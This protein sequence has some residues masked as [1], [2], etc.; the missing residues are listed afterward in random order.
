[1]PKRTP[2]CGCAAGIPSPTRASAT[3]DAIRARLLQFDDVI[4]VRAF[5]NDSQATDLNGVPPQHVWII[6]QGGNDEAIGE[7]IYQLKPAGIGTHG[8][9]AVTV[10][11]ASGQ[12]YAIRFQRP[13]E[14]PLYIDMTIKPTE[15]YVSGAVELIK[16]AIVQWVESN[17]GIGDSLKY[18]R[19]YTPINMVPGFEVTDMNIGTGPNPDGE[20]SIDV[21]V[22][23]IITADTANI[24]ITVET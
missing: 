1:M 14:V 15:G 2:S 18:S 19:L 5:D 21:T 20:T 8:D 22:A 4:A 7:V 6:V 13:S 23:Q 10:T 16:A 17:I 3:L 9:T 12:D 24:S 11:S